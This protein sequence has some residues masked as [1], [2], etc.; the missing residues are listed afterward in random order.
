LLTR[1]S[2]L[3]LSLF[4]SLLAFCHSPLAGQSY[5]ISTSAGGLASPSGAEAFTSWVSPY[6][7]AVD[8]SGTPYFISGNFVFKVKNGVLLRVAGSSSAPGYSGDGGPATSATLNTP[9]GLALDLAGTVFIADTG[10]NCVRRVLPNG[11]IVTIAGTGAYGYTG[12]GSA[13][14]RATLA[15]PAGLAVDSIGNVYIADSGNN[16]VRKVSASGLISTVAGNGSTGYSGD[17]GPAASAQLNNPTGVAV[18]SAQNI[19]VA[20][21][22][23]CVIRKITGA[24]ITTV[25][26]DYSPGYAGDGNQANDAELAYPS[27]IA[28]DRSGD[29]YIADEQNSV[30]RKVSADGVISTVAGT[31]APNYSGD[32]SAAIRAQL[33]FP[34]GIAVDLVGNLYIA[35][36]GNS[37]LREVSASGTITTVAGNGGDTG[38]E[39][40][41]LDNPRGV[42][43]DN[44]GDI[45]VTDGGSNTVREFSISGAVAVL[46]SGVYGYAGDGSTAVT[47]EFSNP[48]GITADFSG[49]VYVVDSYNSRVR[50]IAPG[51]IITTVA[52]NGISGYSGDGLQAT[53]A[54]LNFPL[55]IALDSAGDLYIADTNNSCIRKVSATGVITTIAGD[56]TAGYVGDY[57]PGRAAE[58]NYP[59][60]VAVDSAG[61]VYVAD[62]ANNVIRQLSVG[63]IITT[64][65]GNGV[66]GYSG[67]GG[68][69]TSAEL[70][71]PT[72]VA[73]DVLGNL[74]IADSGNF[75]IRELSGKMI[76]TIAGTGLGGY[77]GDLGPASLAQLG[78]IT[79]L[80]LD[81]RGDVYLSDYTNSLVRMLSPANSHSV[82]AVTQ[83]EVIASSGIAYT[84]TIS[85]ASLAGATSGEVILTDNLPPGLT[86][87]SIY[88][89]GWSCSASTC[90]RNDS[91]AAGSSYPP[92]TITA[93]VAVGAPPQLT[94]VTT[95]SGGGSPPMTAQ[96]LTMLGGGG[97]AQ[98]SRVSQSTANS[99]SQTFMITLTDPNGWQNITLVDVLVNSGLDA[100]RACY[101]AIAPTSAAS[102][103]IYLVDDA[104]DTGG[105]YETVAL[106]SSA[107]AQNS[108]CSISGS[109]SSVSASGNNLTISLDLTFAGKFAGNK[110][111]Y[112]AA[113]NG[114]GNSGWQALST[115]TVPGLPPP[116]GLG[117]GTMTAEGNNMNGET[118]TFTFTDSKGFGDLGVLDVL[119]NTGL[120]AVSACYFA[121]VPTG[122]ASGELYLVDDAGAAG[123][124]FAAFSVP[125]NG[126]AQNSQCS[127]SGLGSSVSVVGT[128]LTLTLPITFN[129]EFAG[130]RLI[131]LSARNNSGE[132]TGWIV[133]GTIAVP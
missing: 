35:D 3:H 53:N 94:N 60:G 47:A 24:V 124:P 48:V 103:I 38:P 109:G 56:G 95:V 42:G 37:R 130:N 100:R 91:L 18:D 72:A 118:F 64:I 101:V 111:L 129:A 104:G 46:G 58:L 83:S 128:T 20:D 12:D 122:Q 10:N 67:D 89:G 44:R 43:I 78:T 74:Y 90:T 13:A 17:G 102:G 88:G 125:G 71:F 23:N 61:N 7:T 115:C 106:P 2:T 108:Q 32:Q 39:D 84:V 97:I 126:G 81:S 41:S 75:A 19:Y 123:G 63:G 113:Q 132:N 45:W 121:F 11:T 120:N 107:S 16:S 112:I 8:T 25:A 93:A 65:G 5:I 133:E 52:G 15:N 31:G 14:N 27:D 86:M 29:L 55:G 92:I 131:F 30:V 105:P 98:P 62:S 73:V 26:G 79:S 127:I 119:V 76:A 51:G 49:N 33:N 87:K 1:I 22:Y 96:I 68:S 117:V 4:F 50:K 80:S 70:N 114:I 82:L 110:I 69:P 36:S 99:L 21:M 28:L 57:G 66:S 77:S 40:L 116:S 54:E 34:S 59:N 9:E 85:N 6:A